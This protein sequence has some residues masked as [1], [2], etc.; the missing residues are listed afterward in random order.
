MGDIQCSPQLPG[1][2]YLPEPPPLP[3]ALPRQQ[4]HSAGEG[5]A[6]TAGPGAAWHWPH[7]LPFWILNRYECIT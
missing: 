2:P 3:T 5:L 6:A 7:V 1:P 4:G